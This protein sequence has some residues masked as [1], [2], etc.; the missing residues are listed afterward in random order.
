[1]ARR[2]G[3]VAIV[4]TPEFMM[5]LPL[6]PNTRKIK[7]FGGQLHRIWGGRAVGATPDGKMHRIRMH[8]KISPDFQRAN[9]SLHRF[10]PRFTLRIGKLLYN[11][12]HS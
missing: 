7:G 1:M 8:D 11:A 3:G 5:A 9:P 10:T 2:V 6:S 4:G 12:I